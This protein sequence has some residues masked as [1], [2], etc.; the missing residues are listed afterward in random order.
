MLV[1][2][3]EDSWTSLA[4]TEILD[5]DTMPFVPGPVI[6]LGRYLCAVVSPPGS[7]LMVG[8]D[9]GYNVLTYIETTEAPSLETMSFAAGPSMLTRR[10]G[11]AALAMPQDES[12]RRALVVGGRNTNERISLATTEVLTGLRGL[13]AQLNTGGFCE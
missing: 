11:C 9:G 2:G 12:P 4:T 3:G 10:S 5:I 1:I 7:I 8:G 13:L 6:S